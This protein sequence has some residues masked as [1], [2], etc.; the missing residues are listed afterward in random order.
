MTNIKKRSEV[1]RSLWHVGVHFGICC[2]SPFWR[3]V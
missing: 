2:M 3:Q 1:Y